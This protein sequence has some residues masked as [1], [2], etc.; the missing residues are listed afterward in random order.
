[1]EDPYFGTPNNASECS[2]P[3]HVLVESYSG[4]VLVAVKIKE[5][6]LPISLVFLESYET[7]LSI[8]FD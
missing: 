1:M 5:P 2:I 3:V 4:L 8:L 7:E 6:E